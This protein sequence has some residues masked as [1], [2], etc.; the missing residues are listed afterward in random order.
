MKVVIQSNC[1]P[2]GL[3]RRGVEA[4]CALLPDRIV[5]QID[6]LVLVAEPWGVEAFEYD[7]KRRVAY[8][9]YPGDSNVREIRE[10]ALRE[11]LL[12]FARLDAGAEFGIRV[13]D[14]QRI[15]FGAFIDQWCP[16]CLKAIT[17]AV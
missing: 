15:E 10:A 16:V 4:A 14:G 17:E 1:G 12:G 6:K 13:T 5:R 11:L 9:A 8:F 3:S 7:P 2:F